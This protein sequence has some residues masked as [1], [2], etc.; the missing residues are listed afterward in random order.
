MISVSILEPTDIIE[1]TDWC[2]PLYL[3]SMSGGHGEGYSFKNA[4]SGKPEN[5][6]KW[7]RAK[8][9]LGKLWIGA[10]VKHY[11]NAMSQFGRTYEFVRGDIPKNHRLTKKE[12][13]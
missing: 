5:N 11:N 9:V 12:Y 2:R 8:D 1:P 4:Y 13:K 6:T 10:T 3:I 7:V